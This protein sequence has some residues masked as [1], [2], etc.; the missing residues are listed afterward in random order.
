MLE[1][2]SERGRRSGS[3]RNRTGIYG[4]QNHSTPVM[5]CGLV[6][7]GTESACTHYL[8]VCRKVCAE[9]TPSVRFKVQRDAAGGDLYHQ[10][11]WTAHQPTVT[12][13][14]DR[15]MFRSFRRPE[16]HPARHRLATCQSLVSTPMIQGPGRGRCRQ[17]RWQSKNRRKCGD[18][19]PNQTLCSLRLAG[20]QEADSKALRTATERQSVRTRASEAKFEFGPAECPSLDGR[21]VLANYDAA[22]CLSSC[23]HEPRKHLFQRSLTIVRSPHAA[24][25]QLLLE[26]PQHSKKNEPVSAGE[27]MLQRMQ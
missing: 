6:P 4:D 5:C 18:I 1:S 25:Q 10:R 11:P 17:V 16:L 9:L 26:F 20:Q 7:P 19:V 27:G 21:A 3:A 12:S 24:G 8:E 23:S 22:N 2:P 14:T 15:E 13:K